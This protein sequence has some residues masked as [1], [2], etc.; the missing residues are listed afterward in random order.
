[1]VVVE[2]R[3]RPATQDGHIDPGALALPSI[4][5]VVVVC[6]PILPDLCQDPVG[7]RSHLGAR[8]CR[9]T[10]LMADGRRARSSVLGLPRPLCHGQHRRRVADTPLALPSQQLLGPAL[11]NLFEVLRDPARVCQGRQVVGLVRRQPL[12]VRSTRMVEVSFL[13]GGRKRDTDDGNSQT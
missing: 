11:R 5:V 2:Q 1:M 8:Q 7:R 13:E 12:K 3:S 6:L 4:V 9:R 10:E